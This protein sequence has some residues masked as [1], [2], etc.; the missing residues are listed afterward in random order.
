MRTKKGSRVKKD[1]MMVL[2][3]SLTAMTEDQRFR[4]KKKEIANA[5]LN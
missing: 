3:L 2:T 5:E 4:A 1:L